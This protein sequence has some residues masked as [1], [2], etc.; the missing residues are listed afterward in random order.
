MAH[1]FRVAWTVARVVTALA[2]L[3]AVAVAAP[4]PV[5][6]AT[7][8]HKSVDVNGVKIFYREAGPASAPT[9]LLLHGFPSSSREFDTL[10]PSLAGQYHLVAPDYPGFGHSDA[11]P[12]DKFSYTF[13]NITNVIN[14]FTETLGLKKYALYVNDYGGPVGFRLALAHPERITA[15]VVQNAVAH[16]DGLD[17]K[18]W[19]GPRAFWADRAKYE[20]QFQQ[21]LTALQG[22]KAR[23]IGS[24]PHP[25]RYSPDLW[26]DE[27]AHLSKPGIAQIQ[28]ELF[29]DYRTNV[30]AYPA[31]QDYLRKYKPPLLVVWGRYDPSFALPEAEAYK[32][33]VPDAEVHVLEAGHFALDE[34]V[35]EIAGIMRPFLEKISQ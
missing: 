34:A 26:D 33:E 11:P 12:P 9:I 25:E 32:R 5:T 28:V 23:H 24:S 7:T 35:D 2:A 20:V 22:A 1:Q 29:Y 21:R 18:R 19:A 27:L 16:N 13:E 14:K 31:W 6:H 17:E 30:A 10:I 3:G 8:V 4:V 15:I